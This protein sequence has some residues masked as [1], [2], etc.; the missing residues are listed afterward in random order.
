MA[1]LVSKGHRYRSRIKHFWGPIYRVFFFKQDRLYFTVLA[2][3]EG[4]IRTKCIA[5]RTH[6]RGFVDRGP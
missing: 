1:E 3:H 5:L 4:D 6:V 2:D